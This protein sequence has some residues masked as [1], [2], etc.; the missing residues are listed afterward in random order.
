MKRSTTLFAAGAFG[1]AFA[2]P[3]PS[4][5]L[6][7]DPHA[8]GHE[9]GAATLQLDHGKKWATDTPLRRGMDAIRAAVI[10]APAP[11]HQG[12]AKPGAYAEVGR[13]VE[14]E[15]GKIVAECKL[16]PAADAQLHLLVAELI[17]GADAM[18]AAKT[19][20]EGRDGLVKVAG[21]LTTYGKYF[22]HP[23]W[24]GAKH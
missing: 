11:L 18:K 13:K 21:T 14:A 1:L 24:K 17:A 12:K 2:M 22:D 8:H 4:A 7:A 23:G 10:G 9:A 3:L 20:A 19:G 15:V 6:A 5:A 16:P